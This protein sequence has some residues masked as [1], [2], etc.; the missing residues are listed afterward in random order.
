MFPVQGNSA[1]QETR[2]SVLLSRARERLAQALPVGWR[3]VLERARRTDSSYVP[4]AVFRVKGPDGT[5]T[6]LI[7]EAK[8][9][10]SRGWDLVIDQMR[11]ARS[12]Q[13]C[14]ALAVVDY[15]GPGFR[16]SCE[17]R[18]INYMDL[19]GWIRLRARRPAIVI[20]TEGAA[21]D[22]VKR[23]APS[24]ARLS[25]PGAGRVLRA[26]LTTKEPVRVRE[27]A[28]RASV[29]PGTVSKVLATLEGEGVVSR[30]AAGNVESIRKRALIER[31]AQDYGILRTNSSAWY[32]A[33]RGLQPLLTRAA[34]G[35]GEEVATGSLALRAYIE[36]D[37]AP[38]AALSQLALYVRDIAS[39]ARALDLAPV[40]A[41]KA[42]VLLLEP[43]DPKLLVEAQKSAVGRVVDLG[44]TVADL[45]TSPGRGRDE[46][47]Q[48]MNELARRDPSWA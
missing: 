30:G 37:M 34:K 2:E 9:A 33:P 24:I 47:Q 22:P 25:G 13:G 21:R 7:V 29:R 35:E 32:L 4:D 15:A 46:A 31:W 10:S 18:D 28:Q 12:S 39:A 36:P 23:R 1:Y 17:A 48:L 14:E 3:V 8:T 41:S 19:T 42:N 11:R 27:L 38:V 20:V 40:D 45:Y 26:L 5:G 43:Y 6:S 44:Q 16:R